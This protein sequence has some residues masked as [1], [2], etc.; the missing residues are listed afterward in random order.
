MSFVRVLPAR[1]S[2]QLLNPEKD[3]EREQDEAGELLGALAQR[4][5]Q[6]RA[7]PETE[8]GDEECLRADQDDREPNEEVQKT[9]RKADR[10][11]VEADRD[12]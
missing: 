1:Q 2:G 6:L 12:P 7:E 3:G 5:V 9:D 11:L 8:L 10:E 4:L